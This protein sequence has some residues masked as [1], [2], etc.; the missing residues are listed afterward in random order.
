MAL[1]KSVR[2]NNTCTFLS[3]GF[4]S[5]CLQNMQLRFRFL[6]LLLLFLFIFLLF[7]LLLLFL[8]RLARAALP[9]AF[10]ALLGAFVGAFQ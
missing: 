7:L 1:D 9:A 8:F 5:L 3:V 2:L 4:I 6:F 10:A